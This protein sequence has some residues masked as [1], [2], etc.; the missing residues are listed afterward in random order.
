MNTFMRLSKFSGDVEDIYEALYVNMRF[1]RLLGDVEDFYKAFF[2][3]MKF[4]RLLWGF[5]DCQIFRTKFLFYQFFNWKKIGIVKIC[6]NGFFA[7]WTN[8][9]GDVNKSI[10]NN[11]KLKMNYKINFDEKFSTKFSKYSFLIWSFL[12]IVYSALV[13]NKY[14]FLKS[15]FQK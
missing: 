14:P 12:S 4:Y 11:F 10:T 2:F 13:L 5:A 1:C 3:I 6:R 9:G 15:P 7:F 8:Y